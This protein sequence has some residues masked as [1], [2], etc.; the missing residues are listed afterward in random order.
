M[1]GSICANNI[2]GVK[3]NRVS[4]SSLACAREK[5]KRRKGPAIQNG[6]DMLV[7]QAK[8]SWGMECTVR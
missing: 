5:E 4:G 8:A 2:K 1:A 3:N 6:F 7:N